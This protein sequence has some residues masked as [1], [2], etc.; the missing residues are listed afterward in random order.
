MSLGEVFVF[1]HEKGNL[2]PKVFLQVRF[3]TIANALSFAD[4]N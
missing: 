4:L 1:A 2:I 3:K